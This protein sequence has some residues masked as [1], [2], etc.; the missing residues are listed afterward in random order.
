MNFAHFYVSGDNP[1][2][3]KYDTKTS[4]GGGIW[5]NLPLCKYA[6][7]ETQVLINTYK[8]QPGYKFG[9]AFQ[10]TMSYVSV[11]LFLKWHVAEPLALTAGA[12]FDFRTSANSFSYVGTEDDFR[13]SG[14]SLTAGFELFPRGRITFFGRYIYGLTNI[15]N[16]GRPNSYEYYNRN[17]QLGLK[18][19]I[20]GGYTA[21]PAAPL[22]VVNAAVDTDGDGIND[23][24]DKCPNQA[25]VAKYAGCPVP[26]TDGD[27]INDESDKCPT[28]KG[29]AK[30]G[31][32]PIPDTDGDGIN[33]EEDKCPNQSGMARYGGCPIPDTDGDGVNDEED[34]CPNRAGPADNFGCPV[35]GIKAYEIAFKSNKAVLLPKSK[36][37]LDTVVTYLHTNT[38]VNVTID[39]HTDNTG[40]DKINDPLS[41]K[42]AEAT[43]AYLV[44]KGIDAA[45]MTTAG[46]GSKKPVADNK[47][48][49]GRRKNRRIE[50]KIQ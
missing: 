15:N 22:P 4:Y 7:V 37:L 39:G 27:G 42:R 35:I 46:Y 13:T 16:V 8:Y 33:D 40:T 11:P 20:F 44:S 5:A 32:C 1:Q 43:K 26:D 30:Y 25:G 10:G 6:S 17:L 29:L 24:D 41:V 9:N 45:R 48:A 19:R 49:Q 28:Q 50:I 3:L 2:G 38:S 12:Q 36:L 47:T 34:K 18:V 31:G 14:T 23:V 21:P